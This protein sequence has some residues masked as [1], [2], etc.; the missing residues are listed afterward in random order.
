MDIVDQ[1]RLITERATQDFDAR[2]EVMRRAA[3][4]IELL[5]KALNQMVIEFRQADLPY[6]SKGYLMATNL[7]CGASKP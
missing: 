7:L 2:D 5:R 6:G 1:L 3:D 4:E